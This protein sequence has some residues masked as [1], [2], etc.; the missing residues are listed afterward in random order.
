MLSPVSED[1]P[2]Q[3]PR[4]G[5]S[6]VHLLGVRGSTPAPGAEFAGTGGHT[7]CVG[8]APAS[9]G[10]EGRWL[11]LDAGTGFRNLAGVLGGAALDADVVLT[12]LHWD[13]V[14]GLP[15]LR[16]ADRPD[17]RIDLWIPA[18][19]E[20]TS[21]AEALELLARGF[22]P[23]SFPIRPDEL[24]GA[25]RFHA[26]VAGELAT[27]VPGTRVVADEV[28]HKG[29][30]T[31]G[32]RVERA[33]RSFAYVPDHCVGRASDEDLDRTRRLC[34]GVDVLFHDSQYLT[35]ER[36]IADDYGHCTVAD[37]VDL[38]VT[39]GAARLVLIHHAPGR[40]DAAIPA[41]L[42]EAIARVAH[43]GAALTVELGRE[44]DVVEV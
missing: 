32:V 25:W 11:V 43:H 33:G 18:A 17:A 13:H 41:A 36:A 44:G 20:R 2:R 19:S 30:T 34:S 5:S 8:L 39:A 26:A 4:G 9:G 6:C 23:P 24:G 35:H 28:H 3:A 27:A 1:H 14:Q 16:H 37:A 10:P 29:G 40:D 15:F 7:S 22:A 42:D 31:F 21:D 38:A 12:H